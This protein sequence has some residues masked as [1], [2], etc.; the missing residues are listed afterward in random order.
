MNEAT[1]AAKLL[2]LFA[3]GGT[4][5]RVVADLPKFKA[6]IESA[7]GWMKTAGRC[8]DTEVRERAERLGELVRQKD[9]AVR[10]GDIDLAAKLRAEECSLFGSFGMEAPEGEAWHT[11]LRVGIDEQTKS[12]SELLYDIDAA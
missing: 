4:L 3:S 1:I 7:Y 11:I 8:T 12:L 9:G 6:Q 5:E 10:H 2:T